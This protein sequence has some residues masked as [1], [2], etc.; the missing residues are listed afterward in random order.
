MDISRVNNI[1]I[2][3][4]YYNILGIEN[5]KVVQDIQKQDESM[6]IDSMNKTGKIECQTCKNRKYV[7][8]STD[9]GVSFKAPGHISPQASFAMVAAH[10][11]EHVS[12]AKAEGAK[13]GNKLISASVRL[14]TS[15]CPE[16]GR[17]YVSGG[18]TSTQISYSDPNKKTGGETSIDED[19]KGR[20][21]DERI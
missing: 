11:N 9:S 6:Q 7:D 10:E 4:S 2:A 18:E 5:D 14:H 15:V 20:V 3:Q 16:C 13:N 21:I 19:L 8:V 1:S 17:V 12:I